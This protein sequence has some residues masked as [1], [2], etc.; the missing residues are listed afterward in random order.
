MNNENQNETEY[1]KLLQGSVSTEIFNGEP[2]DVGMASDTVDN[3]PPLPSDPGW[4]EYVLSKLTPEEFKDGHPVVDGLRRIALELCG[5]IISSISEV[6]SAPKENERSATVVHT[7]TFENGFI[8]SGVSDASK[9]NTDTPYDRHLSSTAETRAEGRALRRA[10]K[11]R[12]VVTAEELT[13]AKKE[14]EKEENIND[15]QI[16]AID[17]LCNKTRGLDIN[18]TKL[19]EHVTNKQLN[20]LVSSDALKIL[21]QLSEYQRG[22]DSIPLEIK[23]YNQDWRNYGSK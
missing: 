23:G 9:Y 1:S 22:S 16:S 20:K 12:H 19:I 18:V 15:I 14:E 2:P 5:E 7:I 6:V 8:Y 3:N 11:L 21:K 13:N 4:S 17:A 10:L